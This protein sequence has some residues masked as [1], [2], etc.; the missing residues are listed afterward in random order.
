L[1]H[2]YRAGW[3]GLQDREAALRQEASS[4]APPDEAN[5]KVLWRM[6]DL[7]AAR[8]VRV[9][10]VFPPLLNRDVLYLSTATSEGAAYRRIAEEIRHRG[11]PL[12]RLDGGPPRNP[13]EF[14]N[15]GHLNDQGAQRYSRL[16]A[17]ALKQIWGSGKV[18]ADGSVRPG[19]A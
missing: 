12:I 2:G 9:A 17:Q 6:F 19:T 1:H 5:I 16:L 15:P 4:E 13:S 3:G 8:G 18:S 7:L 11:I 10:V 14:V